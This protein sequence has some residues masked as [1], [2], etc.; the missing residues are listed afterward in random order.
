MSE[1]E[2]VFLP[3]LTPAKPNPQDTTLRWSPSYIPGRV[4]RPNRFQLLPF[5]EA[6]SLDHRFRAA[7]FRSGD[8][9]V[10]ILPRSHHQALSKLGRRFRG[11]PPFQRGSLVWRALRF[12]RYC[13]SDR[14]AS[15][16]ILG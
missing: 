1:L 10:R 13:R 6:Q 14:H 3:G 2:L 7:D 16:T 5:R 12:S 4:R 8:D 11:I 9:R 15:C